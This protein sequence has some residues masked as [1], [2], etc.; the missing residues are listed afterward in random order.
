MENF[1][2]NYIV[3][4]EFGIYHI[5]LI[6]LF[7]FLSHSWTH[8]CVLTHTNTFAYKF[9]FNDER[10]EKCWQLLL[11]YLTLNFIILL[12]FEKLSMSCGNIFF[13]NEVSRE[14][15]KT[16]RTFCNKT[17]VSKQRYNSIALTFFPHFDKMQF[18]L[19]CLT[20]PPCSIIN[21]F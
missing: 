12:T 11:E 8:M 13:S 16:K 2:T 7:L 20:F 19:T 1:I 3:I 15:N 18:G 10:K 4:L 5:S 14:T 17:V 9:V 6:N 21:K